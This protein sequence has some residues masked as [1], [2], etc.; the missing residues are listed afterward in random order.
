MIETE[1]Y[2]GYAVVWQGSLPYYQLKK[3][4]Q[5]PVPIPLRGY[6]TSK[7]DVHQAVDAY[8]RNKEKP[9]GKTV[10]RRTSK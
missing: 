2:K 8:E 6:Y 10:S 7:K 3:V 5:G 9:S 1:E 4:G